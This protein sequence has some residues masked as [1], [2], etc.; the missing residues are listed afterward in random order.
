[1]LQKI[2]VEPSLNPTLLDLNEGHYDDGYNISGIL[3]L[4]GS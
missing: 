3:S 4:M 1:M 2:A